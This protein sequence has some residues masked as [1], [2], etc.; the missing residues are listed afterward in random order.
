M[1]SNADTSVDLRQLP[2]RTHTTCTNRSNGD[3]SDDGA[4]VVKIGIAFG[5]DM[6]RGEVIFAEQIGQPTEP[7]AQNHHVSGEEAKREFLH[8]HRSS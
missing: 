2:R 4:G 5:Q 6:D 8:V 7:P 3:G 1:E